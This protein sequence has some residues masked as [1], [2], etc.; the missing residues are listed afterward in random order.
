[1]NTIELFEKIYQISK[2][3]PESLSQIDWDDVIDCINCEIQ[4]RESLYDETQ[5]S[6]LKAKIASVKEEIDSSWILGDIISL[7][8]CIRELMGMALVFPDAEYYNCMTSDYM[9]CSAYKRHH[10]ENTTI[11]WGDSHVNFFSGN[12]H[13]DME[14]MINGI[15]LCR[16]VN[17]LPFTVIHMGPALAYTCN[18]LDSFTNFHNKAEFLIKDFIVPGSRIITSLGEIDIRVHVLEQAQKQNRKVEDIIEGIL[19]EYVIFLRSLKKRGYDVFCWGPIASQK[20]DSPQDPMF[21]RVG[22]EIDRNKATAYFN[23]C[24]RELCEKEGIGFMSVFDKMITADYETKSEY[25]SDDNFHLGQR[26][27]ELA[28]PV[29]R[30]AGLI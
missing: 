10:S 12:E 6:F 23:D 11:V 24:M 16:S 25:L 3:H 17:D 21:P 15:N 19:G 2:D 27:M 7:Q 4:D 14:P 28:M 22:S 13:M 29:F 26:A 1:M 18:K 9:Y 5:H 20:D 30:N 8:G